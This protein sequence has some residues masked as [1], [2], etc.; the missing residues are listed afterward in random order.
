MA[1][2]VDDATYKQTYFFTDDFNDTVRNN[3]SIDG[4]KKINT[5]I[6]ENPYRSNVEI[7]GGEMVLQPDLSALF[8]AKGKRHS[9]GGMDVL[10]KPDSFIFSDFKDIKISD[11][12]KEM[13][14]LKKGGSSSTPAEVLK[15]NINP[16]HYNTLINN[17]GDPFKDEL[18]RKSSS[19]MLEKYIGTLGNIAYLQESKK[20]FPDGL[21]A[22][23]LGSAPVMDKDTKDEVDESK[24]YKKYGGNVNPYQSGGPISLVKGDWADQLLTPTG[25][26]V[27]TL[28]NIK[29]QQAINQQKVKQA[30][31]NGNYTGWNPATG[32]YMG[33]P[34]PAAPTRNPQGDIVY[35]S[36]KWGLWQ[37]D[38]FNKFQTTNK[39]DYNNAADKF[40]QG[41]NR[42]AQQLGYTG[43]MDNKSFQKWIYNSSPENKKIVDYW[44][45]KYGA[46]PTAG[47]F[48]GNIGIR[49]QNALN[50][51]MKQETVPPP[52]I[53][54][55]P[56]I[57][58][59][60]TPDA[61]YGPTPG[62]VTGQGN[63]W[64]TADWE[65]TPW[66]KLSQ[67][68]NWG[69]YAGVQRYMPFRSRYN[70]TY[71]D[72]SLLNPEQTVGDVKGVYNQ[73]LKGL[74]TLNPI[75]RQAA[76]AQSYGQALNTIPGIRTQYDNQNAQI[77]NQF[78]QYNNQVRNNESMVNMANDQNYYQ[79]AVTARTNFNNMRQYAGD[80]AMSGVLKDAE[81][82]TTLSYKLMQQDHP[83]YRFDFRSGNFQRNPMDIRDVQSSP[84]SDYMQQILGS[85]DAKS[86]PDA[87]KIKLLTA[88]QR[89]KA[90]QYLQPQKKG[91]KIPRNPYK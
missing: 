34:N 80:Q 15:Q 45:D 40:P 16:K 91:G 41:I 1:S 54:P 18:A 26:P 42:V 60:N 23:S 35:P 58:P 74:N 83:A 46:G 78:R 27:P 13:F 11:K 47:K 3:P 9:Q 8:K 14:E 90:L 55:P 44:H 77:T 61:V 82:N 17:I 64:K 49:W 25:A 19:L 6:K 81:D 48:D 52:G 38:K 12:D 88:L 30:V 71:A 36:T 50:Q 22:F 73:Q 70:A 53:N 66:Q 63:Q 24:Q 51:I 33:A 75:M 59:R 31:A 65:F 67:M 89:G 5:S 72:P 57:K 37:G 21:P 84:Q 32:Q 39:V 4:P 56:G 62:N 29:L 43:P 85:I 69:R 10:L 7:E 20:N 76:A 68:Y 2:K 86:L 28:E 79:Q 87:D